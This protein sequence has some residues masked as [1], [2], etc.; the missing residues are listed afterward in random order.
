M[1]P[2]GAHTLDEGSLSELFGIEM[3]PE[4]PIAPPDPKKLA[5]RV[6]PLPARNCVELTVAQA[7]ELLN[8]S[9]PQLTRL[10]DSGTLPALGVGRQ[11]KISFEEILRYRKKV[12]QS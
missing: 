12:R 4:S 6:E 5:E 3:A 11:R 10:I 9:R 8:L 7:A 2:S 1:T